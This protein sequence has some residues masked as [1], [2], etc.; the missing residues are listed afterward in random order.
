MR[1][2]SFAV[3][4]LIAAVAAASGL[5]RA[6]GPSRPFARRPTA[7]VHFSAFPTTAAAPLAAQRVS[8][9]SSSS[10]NDAAAPQIA[11][12]ASDLEADLSDEERTV[13]GVFRQCGP[14]VAYVT[15]VSKSGGSATSTGRRRRGRTPL[16]RRRG[17]KGTEDGQEGEKERKDDGV[18]PNGVSLGSGSGFV[19]SDDGYIVTNYHVVQRAYQLTEGVKQVN[20]EIDDL[21]T[22][23]TDYLFGP[24]SNNSFVES[25]ANRTKTNLRFDEGANNE[26]RA[27]VYVRINS[28]TKYRECRLVDVRPEIDLAVLKVVSLTNL[29]TTDG[30]EKFEPIPYGSSSSLLVGQRL[31]AIGNPFGL[32]QTVTSGVV[33]ALNREMQGVG[34]NTIR[35]CIQTDAAINPGNSGGPLLDSKGRLVGVNTAIITTSGSNAGIGF[36]VPSDK[37]KSATDEIIAKDRMVTNPQRS[38]P[39]WLGADIANPDL[40]LALV[41]RIKKEKKGSEGIGL[42]VSKVAEGS[43]AQKA[44]LQALTLT[45]KGNVVLGDRIVALGGKDISSRND[46]EE[47]MKSRVEGEQVTLTLEDK[48]GERRVVYI[49]LERKKFE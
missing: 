13:I 43:P 14:S 10:G 30:G 16:E 20:K 40:S 4:V 1:V 11:V 44:G 8:L 3:G 26:P 46:L 34:G 32:D 35:G 2:N 45:E 19:V 17:R 7:P 41:K 36:A 21:V 33:S 31:I 38:A 37:V 39:G 29:T 9:S 25:L 23:T 49:T 22:N 48:D 28:S 5:C 24:L 27:S 42:F 12:K 6:F 15:S 18:L 47:D